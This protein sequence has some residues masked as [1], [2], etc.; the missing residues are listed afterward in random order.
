MN[1]MPKREF[2]PIPSGTH[3]AANSE[4]QPPAKRSKNSPIL[5]EEL[6]CSKISLGVPGRSAVLAGRNGDLYVPLGD[7][8]GGK[9]TFS[10]SKLPDYN[11]C[12]FEAGPFAPTP[13]A[14]K[15]KEDN[16]KENCSMQIDITPERYDAWVKFE[17]YLKAKLFE[18]HC[19]MFPQHD[20]K[21]DGMSREMFEDKFSS[22]VSP[23]GE[24]YGPSLRIS[25]TPPGAVYR[26]GRPMAS[27]NIKTTTLCADM[28]SITKPKDGSV[29]DIT[30]D[31]A[32]SPIA[33]VVRGVYISP[34]G[35]WG[36]KLTLDAAYIVLNMAE[37][38]ARRV[39]T[40][41][42]IVVGEKVGA[43]AYAQ[44]AQL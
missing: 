26:D 36:I 33:S 6:D 28:T 41:N 22:I 7:T 31:C 24:K 10:F 14:A 34:T 32:I 19:E 44:D 39:D 12:L 3:T 42:A 21:N 29:R 17:D 43:P 9:L 38:A 37:T 30:R 13:A 15:E 4:A 16:A 11:R 1:P 18:H 5:I 23:A 25:V 8:N 2:R 20:K 27:P 40:P 35:A